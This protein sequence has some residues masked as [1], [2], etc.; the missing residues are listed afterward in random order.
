MGPGFGAERRTFEKANGHVRRAGG[1]K[2][3][4]QCDERCAAC[5]PIEPLQK[6][7]KQI[8]NFQLRRWCTLAR[9]P[10]QEALPLRGCKHARQL[11][12]NSARR[13]AQRAEPHDPVI[14]GVE[15][16]F[17]HRDFAQ[18]GDACFMLVIVEILAFLLVKGFA[19]PVIR[20]NA[21]P[22][23]TVARSGRP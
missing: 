4:K 22:S 11:P 12:A 13:V 3:L 8:V 20:V 9:Q 18:R 14:T 6:A 21:S 10:A 1:C 2:V 19:Y 16:D 7:G 15:P 5:I 17:V 23:F